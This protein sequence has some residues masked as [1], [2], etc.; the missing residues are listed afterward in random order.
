[1][2]QTESS[3]AGAQKLGPDSAVSVRRVAKTYGA[4]EALR[5]MPLEFP[6]GQHT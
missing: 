3:F 5:N 4:V 6:S 1:M 2:S